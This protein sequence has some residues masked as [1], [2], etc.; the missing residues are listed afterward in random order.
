ML[1]VPYAAVTAAVLEL[2]VHSNSMSKSACIVLSTLGIILCLHIGHCPF[3][4]SCLIH[5]TIQCCSNQCCSVTMVSCQLTIWK[6]CPH[7]PET[8][9][10]INDRS[11]YCTQK[12]IRTQTAIIPWVFT[13][14]TGTIK[15]DLTD[16]ADVVVGD[17]PSPCSHRVPL[18][19]LDFHLEGCV[20]IPTKYWSSIVD[21]I[22]GGILAVLCC[23]EPM[24][25]ASK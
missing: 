11:R 10:I 15:V 23:Q 24:F 13:S 9:S 1:L 5:S 20:F 7:L 8:I 16:S 18:A 2:S 19:N 12:L 14:R 17:V 21:L 25:F 4:E 6:L 22:S 3:E